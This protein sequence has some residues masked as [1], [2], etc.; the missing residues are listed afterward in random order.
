[1]TQ[2]AIILLACTLVPGHV[3]S[4]TLGDSLSRIPIEV[5][6]NSDNSLSDKCRGSCNIKVNTDQQAIKS[7]NKFMED[8]TQQT[9]CSPI[10][11]QEQG[12]LN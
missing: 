12:Q 5:N 10:N 7:Y 8:T 9:E 3:Y 6:L 11:A 1:M 2:C 4:Q